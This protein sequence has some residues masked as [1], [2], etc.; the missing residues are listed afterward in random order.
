M[1]VATTSPTAPASATSAPTTDPG[2]GS[3][4]TDAFTPDWYTC[5]I[6]PESGGDPNASGGEFGWLDYSWTTTAVPYL[7]SIG[8]APG[9]IASVPAGAPMDQQVA[10]TLHLWAMNGGFG[11]GAWNNAAGCGKAGP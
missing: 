7:E 8:Y 6:T 5:V 9:A 1:P 11:P 2:S 3:D 10:A 4:A